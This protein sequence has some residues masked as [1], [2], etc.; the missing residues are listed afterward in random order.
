M[1][2]PSEELTGF[3]LVLL[4]ERDE[5]RRE[6]AAIRDRVSALA[7]E[8][9]QRRRYWQDVADQEPSDEKRI[10]TRALVMRYADQVS[11]LR[12]LMDGGA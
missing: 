4:A 1:V 8:W 9:D 12:A 11:A 7:D 10:R 2:R 5:A 6:L 3:E